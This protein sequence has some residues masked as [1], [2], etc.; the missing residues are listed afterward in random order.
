MLVLVLVTSIVRGYVK[1][2][3][4]TKISEAVNGY[5]LLENQL[6]V[7]PEDEDTLVRVITCKARGFVSFRAF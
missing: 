7:E 4:G 3:I 6:Q 1:C 5:Q 2:A